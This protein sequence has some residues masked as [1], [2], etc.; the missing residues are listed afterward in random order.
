MLSRVLVK[1]QQRV[2]IVDDL[3]DRLG[4]LGPEVG[5]ERLTAIWAWSMS[6]AW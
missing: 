6:S 2:Q 3:G 5:L 1:L 4:V